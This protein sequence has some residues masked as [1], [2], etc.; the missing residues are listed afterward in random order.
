MPHIRYKNADRSVSTTPE[1]NKSNNNSNDDSDGTID[2][3]SLLINSGTMSA[4]IRKRICDKSPLALAGGKCNNNHNQGKMLLSSAKLEMF[5]EN[6][7]F[8][9]SFA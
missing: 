2:L 4:T 1:I 3:Q 9:F 8:F 7:L 6:L 5:R